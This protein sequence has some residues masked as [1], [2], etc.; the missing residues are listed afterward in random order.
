MRLQPRSLESVRRPALSA[1]ILAGG[2]G[3]RLRPLT[4]QIAGDDRPKQFYP[5]LGRQSL[6]AETRSRAAELI[7]PD[8]T[9]LVLTRPHERFYRPVVDDLDPRLVVVQ[10]ENRGTAPAILYGLLRAATVEP[11]STVAIL[12]SDHWVSDAAAFMAHVAAGQAV[13]EE[14]PDLTV[15]LG[16]APDRPEIEYEWIEPSQPISG[17]WSGDLYQVRRFVEK[18]SPAL[19]RSLQVDRGLWNS[20]VIVG[21][22]TALLARIDEAVPSLFDAFAETCPLFETPAEA[23]AIERLYCGIPVVD[24]SR[25]VLAART[26]NLAVLAVEG[27]EWID[28]GDPARVLAARRCAGDRPAAAAV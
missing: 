23:E 18:P 27:V 9:F 24:F 22:V 6:L 5:V 19:A 28:V 2:G 15:L 10:P 4:R 20:L 13:V 3:T 11:W 1:L 8:H 16:I 21:Q 26:D 25:Q 14:R 12:P 7:P 17:P